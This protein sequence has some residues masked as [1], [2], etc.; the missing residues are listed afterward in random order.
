MASAFL[1]ATQAASPSALDEWV[2][3]E[4]DSPACVELLELAAAV[5]PAGLRALIQELPKVGGASW[6]QGADVERFLGLIVAL[7]ASEDAEVTCAAATAFLAA[8]RCLGNGTPGLFHPLALHELCKSLPAVLCSGDAAPAPRKKGRRKQQQDSDEDEEMEDVGAPPPAKAADGLAGEL[9]RFL[10]AVPL[11]CYPETLSQLVAALVEAAARGAGSRVYL[12]LTCC[13]GSEHGELASTA[14]TVLRSLKPSLT[15]TRETSPNQSATEAQAACVDFLIRLCEHNADDARAHD[16]PRTKALQ[17]VVQTLLQHAA[18]GAPDKAEARALVCNAVCAVL[19]ALPT[20][21]AV[22]YAGFLLRYSRTSKV[23][24]RVFSVEMAST[25][26]LAAAASSSSRRT[27]LTADGVP[28]ILWKLLVQRISDKAP[29]VRTKSLGCVAVLLVKLHAEPGHRLLLQVQMPVPVPVPAAASVSPMMPPPPGAMMPPAVLD[30]SN[31]GSGGPVGSPLAVMERGASSGAQVEAASS[32]PTIG[33]LLQQRCVDERPAVRRAALQ[34]IEA[35]ARASGMQVSGSQLKLISRGCSDVSPAIRKQAARSL[36]AMLQLEPQSAELQAAWTSAILPLATDTEQ[37][38]C[39][40][41]LDTVLE[42][43]LKPLA[44]SKKPRD[45]A[46]WPLLLQ[47]P[48][49]AMPY[50]GRAVRLLARQKR[51]PG[52]LAPKLQALLAEPPQPDG[53]AAAGGRPVVWSLLAEMARLPLPELTQQ[54]LDHAAVLRCWELASGGEAAEQAEDAASALQLLVC[55]SGRSLL[56]TELALT[57]RGQLVERL[58]RFDASPQLAVLLVQ[59]CS[60]LA[61]PAAREPWAAALLQQCEARLA[62]GG[63]APADQRE[64]RVC[65]I[66]VGEVALVAPR[67]VTPSLVASLQAL[68]RGG[69]GGGG[70]APASRAASFVALGKVCMGSVEVAQRLL[71][72][73]MTA[74][75]SH[76]DAAVRSNALVI[77]FDLAKRHTALLER[78]F[79][80]MALALYDAAASV[81]HSALLLFSQ[82]LLEDYV[83]WRPTLFRAFCVALADVEPAVRASA[84]VCLFQLLLP[85]SPLLAFNSFAG[86]LFQINGCTQHAQHSATLSAA[87]S[88]ALEGL[89]GEGLSA[90]RRRLLIF[91]PLLGCMTGEQK[92]QTMAKLS[93]D[94]RHKTRPPPSLARLPPPSLSGATPT[95]ERLTT[96]DGTHPRVRRRRRCWVRCRSGSSHSRTFSSYSRTRWCCW[97]ARRSSSPPAARAPPAPPTRPTRPAHP[98]PPRRRR[99]PR[100]TA[101]CCPRWRARRR[102]RPS[103]P[104]WLS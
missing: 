41:C 101:S 51:L 14:R 52:G 76:E 90:Q 32:L 59:A 93:Q 8:L 61:S 18:V 91:R 66:A 100:R 34:A 48:E 67:A 38:V 27:S 24:A 2:S 98:T 46:G 40:A 103:C 74:L 7:L 26:L 96:K 30:A 104:W 92:L 23:G 43:V 99:P 28:Q 82:L 47:L 39:D 54:K 79:S 50:L 75:T 56:A 44:R 3:G 5:S 69:G 12:P 4:R 49:S 70:A 68:A 87:E 77:L 25:V 15:L 80:T 17:H 1:T 35:W 89:R 62:A 21:E 88:T 10:E 58:Q 11:V 13:L 60:S 95:P 16:E 64:L 73:F 83:K 9:C 19:A 55:L 102:W 36:W 71:P 45:L 6:L 53:A 20:V 31:G 33:A 57:L 85:R 63:A 29:G 65:A 72:V 86:L 84:Q 81:R 42:G 22:R 94:V 97:R 37:T 78:H